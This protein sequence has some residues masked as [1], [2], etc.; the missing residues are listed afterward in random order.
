MSGA[1]GPRIPLAERKAALVAATARAR[2][3]LRAQL[4]ADAVRDTPAARAVAAAGAL[5]REPLV[6]GGIAVLVVA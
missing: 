3:E 2:I 4:S 1:R 5:L 6:V